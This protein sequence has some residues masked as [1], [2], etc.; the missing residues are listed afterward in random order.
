MEIVTEKNNKILNT[1]SAK[2]FILTQLR[3]R[4]YFQKRVDF[5][6]LKNA[7]ELKTILQQES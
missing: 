4:G 6:D 1:I 3:I 2:K 5:Q 7:I